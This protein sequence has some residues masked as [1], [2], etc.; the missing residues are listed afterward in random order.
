MVI[1]PF[2]CTKITHFWK[3]GQFTILADQK[4]QLKVVETHQF[5]GRTSNLCQ[6]P[7]IN[8]LYEKKSVDEFFK[9]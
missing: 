9:I 4:I 2:R 5:S 8:N 7:E 3:K 6:P 1:Y